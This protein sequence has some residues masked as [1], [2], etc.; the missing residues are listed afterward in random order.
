MKIGRALLKNILPIVLFCTAGKLHSQELLNMEFSYG[1]Q[2]PAGR[3]QDRFGQNFGAD[4]GIFVLPGTS[5][6]QLGL[7]GGML[8][9]DKV[10]EDV[11][12]SLRTSQGYIYGNDKSV[13]NIQ[14]RMRGWKTMLLIGKD[15]SFSPAGAIQT[16]IG[17]G[18]LSHK[19][20]IQDDPQRFVP[21]LDTPYK[22]G[23]DRLE[24]G[25]LLYSWL[26]YRHRGIQNNLNFSVGMEAMIAFTKGM[27]SFQ[28]D[29]MQPYLDRQLS[30]WIG[31]KATWVLVLSDKASAQNWY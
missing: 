19:I 31:I 18:Y 9:G 15:W 23:Y 17:G 20:R 3:L 5:G 25:P 1:I 14:L 12:A 8:F 24:G 26:G 11:L 27:R 16:R 4:L 2:T 6:L 22:R 10:K 13:A 30:A 7:A 21:Q 28:Y 29:L